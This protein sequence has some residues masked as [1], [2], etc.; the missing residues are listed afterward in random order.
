M[1]HLR[2]SCALCV[3]AC[4]S[5]GASLIAPQRAGRGRGFAARRAD[6]DRC[7][8]SRDR[9]RRGGSRDPNRCGRGRVVRRASETTERDSYLAYNVGT[10]RGRCRSVLIDAGRRTG[11]VDPQ[12]DGRRYTAKVK[13]SGRDGVVEELRFDDA[14]EAASSTPGTIVC[15][16]DGSFSADHQAHALLGG[17]FAPHYTAE[18]G[19]A[20]S[21]ATRLRLLASCFCRVDIPQTGSRRRR[22]C[23]VDIPWRRVDAAAA[24]WRFRGGGSTPRPRR[25]DSVEAGRG[26]AAAATWIFRGGGSRR[27]RGCDVDTPWRRIAAAAT[28]LRE[29]KTVFDDFCSVGKL[30]SSSSRPSQSRGP[31]SIDAARPADALAE[32]VQRGCDLCDARRRGRRRPAQLRR[33]RWR[34]AHV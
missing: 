1:R 29:A 24:T 9:D 10:W 25:G 21:D 14:D 31:T 13:K 28:E 19:L 26:A 20:V 8:G 2:R 4:A 11:S 7:G 17:G 34:L 23:D 16:F 12:L 3:A 18:A 27:R 5:L 30:A 22:G 32:R 15:D 33:L 6:L